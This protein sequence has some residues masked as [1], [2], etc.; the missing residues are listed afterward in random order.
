MEWLSFIGVLIALA[1]FIY[2]AYKGY[3]IIFLT[4]IASIIVAVFGGN[5]PI[6]VLNDAYA[7]RFSGFIKSWFLIYVLSATFA[8]FMGESGAA[9]SIAL[10]LVKLSRRFPGH[11]KFIAILTLPI[12][13]TILTYGG[14]SSL[15]CVFIMVGIAKD[16]FTELDIP[17]HFYGMAALGSATYALGALPGAPDVLNLTPTTYLGTTPM[18]APGYGI[19]A[20][21]IMFGLSCVYLRIAL[22]KATAAGETFLPTG[23]AIAADKN[24]GGQENVEYPLWKSILPPI[25]LLVVMNVLKQPVVLAM[26]CAI[27]TC[28]VL[29][30]KQLT[31]KAGI[32]KA[33]IATGVPNGAVTAALISATV[34]FGAVVAASPAYTLIVN[35]LDGISWMHPAWQVFITVNVCAALTSSSTSAIGIVFG[36][37]AERFLATG[38]APAAIH[39][40]ATVTSL[41]LNTL[42][43]SVGVCNAAGASKL[44]IGQ[45][46][47]HYLWI[48]VIF[49]LV[50]AIV[51]V[52]LACV[53]IV[54]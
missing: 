19:L 46:Y 48:T 45:I 39:R 21:I 35:G 34:A 32:I 36:Q 7:A 5:N 52:L 23:A 50:S 38:L 15:V 25:V 30:W 9:R 49:P 1:V 20:T 40:I 8:K 18:A 24:V 14:V 2:F 54:F 10:K 29:F 16:L 33:C 28:L 6:T 41:G 44:T 11:E 47:K 4:I 26:I 13:N 22:K 51:L 37:F 17:W 31:A 53:G 3:N 27:L 43:H 12:I 42:P